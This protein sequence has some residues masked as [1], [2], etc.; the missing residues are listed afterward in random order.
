MTESF[1]SKIGLYDFLVI[2]IPGCVIA[3]VISY[4]T[5][6]EGILKY[7]DSNEYFQTELIK[8]IAFFL[9]A[10]F[11]GL[12]NHSIQ[13][14]FWPIL[15][16]NKGH[17]SYVKGDNKQYECF[18]SII[19]CPCFLLRGVFMLF[20]NLKLIFCNSCHVDEEYL[21]S[22]YVAEKRHRSS[23]GYL[24]YQVAF[25]RN[26]L[27]PV[28]FICYNINKFTLLCFLLPV[29]LYYLM[30]GLQEK[31]YKCV[32]EDAKYMSMIGQ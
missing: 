13:G 7:V 3:Y 32:L 22:Y 14:F 27:I 8:N 24:E 23:I 4:C 25:I 17:I 21:K 2:I 30:L 12:L 20:Y 1:F 10:Y 9:S 26:M 15:R 6:V 18:H 29:F 31:I 11:V 5:I 16:N 28:S 19:Q